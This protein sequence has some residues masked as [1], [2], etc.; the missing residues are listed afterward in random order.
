MQL[1]GGLELHLVA[2]TALRDIT[3]HGHYGLSFCAQSLQTISSC[4]YWS[5]LIFISHA[6]HCFLFT[7]HL[8]HV[9]LPSIVL[10]SIQNMRLPFLVDLLFLWTFKFLSIWTTFHIPIHYECCKRIPKDNHHS[11]FEKDEG[12]QHLATHKHFNLPVGDKKPKMWVPKTAR[13]KTIRVCIEYCVF[14]SM[15]KSLYRIFHSTSQ[16]WNWCKKIITAFWE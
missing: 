10:P 6:T 7:L 3:R 5:C 14:V 16:S 1:R 2:S 11:L 4:E 9:K 15:H 8:S 12:H 13:L